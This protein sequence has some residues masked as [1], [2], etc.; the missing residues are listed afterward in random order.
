MCLDLLLIE[1]CF[2]GPFVSAISGQGF[3][4]NVEGQK[5][6]KGRKIFLMS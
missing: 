5:K 2:A 3:G 6:G 4:D 1:K